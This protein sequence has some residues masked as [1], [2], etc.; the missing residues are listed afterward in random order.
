MTPLCIIPAKSTSVRCPNK[1]WRPF[2]GSTLV[3]VA[4]DCARAA[5]WEPIVLAD[6]G[7]PGGLD[8]EVRIRAEG[9]PDDTWACIEGEFGQADVLLLQPT[10]PLRDPEFVVACMVAAC[11]GTRYRNVTAWTHRSPS[12]SVYVRWAGTWRTT[13]IT[14]ADPDPFD[15]DTPEQFEA[16]ERAYSARMAT[17]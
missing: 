16:A 7:Y 5:G 4:V 1:N 2:A 12:G 6:S 15:I 8:C 10:S 17:A 3:Q 9:S 14:L 11:G 13:G